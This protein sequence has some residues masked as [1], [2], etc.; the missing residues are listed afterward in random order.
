MA[1]KLIVQNLTKHYGDVQAVRGVSFEIA[2]GE[3]FGL[4]GPNGAGKTST[5][6]CVIGLRQPD[7]G[8]I[9]VCGIDAVAH[10]RALAHGGQTVVVHPAGLRHL[11]PAAHT[12]LFEQVIDQGGL[13]I[14]EYDLGTVTS[15]TLLLQR[16]RIIAALAAG[17]LVIEA[18]QR[19]AT[20]T[21]AQWAKTLGRPLMAVPGPV[22]SAA[23]AGCHQLI[24]DGAHLVS[25]AQ[26]IL[27]ILRGQDNQ[28][29]RS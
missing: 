17:V 24:R 15:R 9:E 25:N 6:E 3:I 1:P 16:N 5:L 26:D 21:T 14:S 29:G 13:I 10:Q 18:G 19:S 2:K 4:L 20:L 28:L 7:G 22:T 23:S 11:H 12:Q 27:N 8:S